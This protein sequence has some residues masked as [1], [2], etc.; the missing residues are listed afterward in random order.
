VLGELVPRALDAVLAVASRAQL[1]ELDGRAGTQPHVADHLRG[2]HREALGDLLHLALRHLFGGSDVGREKVSAGVALLALAVSRRALADV[3]AGRA[4]VAD[5]V[6]LV[7][8]VPAVDADALDLAV[9]LL[10]DLEL[11]DAVRDGERDG[12]AARRR[13]GDGEL[14]VLH[15]QLHAHAV[16][17]AL[18]ELRVGEV[19]LQHVDFGAARRFRGQSVVLRDGVQRVA[20]VAVVEGARVVLET[21]LVQR[22]L[23]D[24]HQ[25]DRLIAAELRLEAHHFAGEDVVRARAEAELQIDLRPRVELVA[26]DELHLGVHEQ[27]LGLGEHVGVEVDPAAHEAAL[28]GRLER[29]SPDGDLADWDAAIG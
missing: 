11:L 16:G 28:I 3:A 22:L 13:R 23:G 12:V 15:L 10:L 25:R 2:Q 8:G 24:D 1:V 14:L 26:V 9:G 17:H 27:Q 29:T 18:Q 5:D 6:G 7:L 21:Q 20:R 4:R 19:V